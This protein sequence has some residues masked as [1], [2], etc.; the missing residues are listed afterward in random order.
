MTADVP[1]LIGLIPAAGQARRLG[2]LP[3]SKEIYPIGFGP[4]DGGPDLRPKAACQYL[5]E[6]MRAAGARKVFIVLRDGKWDIPAYLG[7]G[8]ALDVHLAYLIMRL[9]FGVPYTLDQAY[10]FVRHAIVALG[11]PDLLF[12]P[13]DAYAQLLERQADRS[14]EIVLGLFPAGRPT[15]T[16]RVELDRDGRVRAVVTRARQGDSR[17]TWILAVWTPAFTQFMHEHLAAMP[18]S[19]L[20]DGR[21]EG[22]ELSMSDVIRAAIDEGLTVDSVVFSE[23][24]FVDIGTPEDLVA[25]VREYSRVSR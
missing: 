16:D 19:G 10:P 17:A 24:R 6:S 3:C 20:A 4:S 8:Y 1:E 23:G 13:A 12:Q 14:A 25:T 18:V 11:F 2:V 15:K 22:V 7:D 5:L 21:R 9:P